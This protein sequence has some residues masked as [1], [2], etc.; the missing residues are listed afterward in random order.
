ME[1]FCEWLKKSLP[2]FGQMQSNFCITI[3]L[4]PYYKGSLLIFKDSTGHVH[5]DTPHQIKNHCVQQDP[6][7]MKVIAAILFPVQVRYEVKY[8][9][10]FFGGWW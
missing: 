8:E 5:D 6:D 3:I 9:G 4:Q 1:L 10:V 2:V 7:I